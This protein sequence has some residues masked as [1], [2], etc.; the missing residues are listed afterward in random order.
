MN[1]WKY[2]IALLFLVMPVLG[3]AQN[4]INNWFINISGLL[5]FNNSP[6]QLKTKDFTEN[7]RDCKASISAPNGELLFYVNGRYL[8]QNFDSSHH[9][10]LFPDSFRFG[11]SQGNLILPKP[12]AKDQ[13]YIFSI[14]ND[15]GTHATYD[16]YY[17]IYDVSGNSG[18]GKLI[19]KQ[20]L[21]LE[22]V[23][24]KLTAT[25]HGNGKAFWLL[26]HG[27]GNNHFYAY[28]INSNG[29]QTPIIS[30]TGT[31]HKRLN[32]SN[33][34]GEMKISPDGKKIGLGVTLDG[35]LEFFDFNDK[36]G[37][38][39]NSIKINPPGHPFMTQFTS[40]GNYFYFNS[41]ASDSFSISGL[42]R[43]NIVSGLK[44]KIKNS[45]FKFPELP[46]N[47]ISNDHV[48]EDIQLGPDGNLY[49]T[50]HLEERK[51]FYYLNFVSN[52][53]GDTSNLNYSEDIVNL[54]KDLSVFLPFEDFPNF[55]SF[56]FRKPLV[57]Y[58]SEICAGDT[59]NLTLQ[60]TCYF[61]SATWHFN[62]PAS[63]NNTATTF[64]PSHHYTD[65]GLY[66]VQ[67]IAWRGQTSDTVVKQVAV[68]DAST[69]AP[70]PADT[71][72]CQGDTLRID[73]HKPY[74]RLYWE[75][76][77]SNFP[78]KAHEAKEYTWQLETGCGTHKDSFNLGFTQKPKAKLPNDTMLCQATQLTLA[79]K[80]SSS[81]NYLWSTG[82][83]GQKETVTKSGNYWLKVTNGCGS[84]TDTTQV[85]MFNNYQLPSN[86]RLCKG[87][88]FE[89][90]FNHQDLSYEWSNGSNKATIQ[91]QET[92]QYT[93]TL[94]HPR[95][96]AKTEDVDIRV[97]ETP[98]LGLPSDTTACSQDGLTLTANPGYD[99]YQ[100]NTGA[101][102]RGIEIT[103]E[104]G[105]RLKAE[106]G[107]CSDRH[108]LYVD[109][110]RPP[111]AGLADTLR[112]CPAEEEFAT[113]KPAK[114]KEYQWHSNGSKARTLEVTESGTYAVTL[115]NQKG[116]RNADSIKAIETCPGKLYFPN[117][118]TPDGD[119]KNENF[120]PRGEG[121]K[122][123]HLIIYNRWGT[124]IFASD[125]ITQGWDG[126]FE[127]SQSPAGVYLYLCTY[128]AK[129]MEGNYKF[130]A[131]HGELQLIR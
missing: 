122:N 17:H 94:S 125:D 19:S 128:E 18:Q 44:P 95:C 100:W 5:S 115:T 25:R 61:D 106:K 131:R 13:Y 84:A 41:I 57:D 64:N 15:E 21:L 53:A 49:F 119:G 39:S 6:P 72:I 103:Q 121:I 26:K 75:G 10:R 34:Y 62:D 38:V 20:N 1:L 7:G 37:T 42:Y 113:L 89:P 73:Y 63:G 9:L 55:P 16:L 11:Q 110:S 8:Y 58:Q 33:R 27:Y 85:G 69:I 45:L 114:A 127:G 90:G 24:I 51:K 108:S 129:T 59:A 47:H 14:A 48:I 40:C 102:T 109:F 56:Y 52:P 32:T 92:G 118:F 60:N 68:Q 78:I 123:Y 93:I 36:T 66:N 65:T 29:I 79:N 30:S 35:Y 4:Q 98:G 76:H 22:D 71:Q 86:A 3:I 124:K 116:C 31:I 97:D 104:S 12:G 112:I 28:K 111:E 43:F 46:T 77:Y 126:A 88:V 107:K 91:P 96:G 82:S 81:G 105:Y 74:K 2:S 99:H 130:E 67:L 54:A 87:E 80:Q 50:H 117:A 120:R 70:F 83:K 23:A 101:T